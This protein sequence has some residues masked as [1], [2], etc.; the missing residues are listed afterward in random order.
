MSERNKGRGI[1]SS[2]FS[3]IN[4]TVALR[5]LTLLI[6]LVL[7]LVSYINYE[8]MVEKAKKTYFDKVSDISGEITEGFYNLGEKNNHVSNQISVAINSIVDETRLEV[9][10]V[11]DIEYITDETNEK[12]TVTSWLKVT[13]E[14]IYT[15]DL[16][17][18]EYLYDSTSKTVTV[19]L[20]KPELTHC[21]L[22]SGENV[23]YENNRMIGNGNIADG[24]D[25]AQRQIQSGYKAIYTYFLENPQFYQSAKD[26]AVSI[27][28]GLIK[29]LYIDNPNIK[30]T[31]VFV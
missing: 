1:N 8:R 2:L 15:V 9:L 16:K 31:V 17:T 14:G 25:L 3:S 18:A 19:V 24:E 7:I 26:S 12:K 29:Q 10:S 28:K 30:V 20:R 5:V 11:R 27:V 22:I 21:R 13:G 4:L 6:P 23:L